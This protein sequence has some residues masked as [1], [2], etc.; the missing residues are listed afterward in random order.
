MIYK[1]KPAVIEDK[2]V[3]FNMFQPYLEEL[4]LFPG[5]DEGYKDDNGVYHYPYLD[6]Y[7]QKDLRHPY[8]LTGDDVVAGFV[9]VRRFNER[10]QIAEFYVSPEVRGISLDFACAIEIIKR[11]PGRW[12]IRFNKY[13][14]PVGRF[15]PKVAKHV[16]QGKTRKGVADSNHY[17]TYFYT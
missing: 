4:S 15:W 13:N 5:E 3:I 6:E 1:L 16:S 10:W 12:R 14:L 8:L 17:Y 7:W 9:L 11:H 2:E